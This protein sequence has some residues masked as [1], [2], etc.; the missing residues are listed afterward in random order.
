M[1]PQRLCGEL[2]SYVRCYLRQKMLALAVAA[3]SRGCFY[4]EALRVARR[5]SFVAHRR[6]HAPASGRPRRRQ[7]P[8][9]NVTRSRVS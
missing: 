4:R 8:T 3:R 7:P 5:I 2:H 9:G 1:L 6:S